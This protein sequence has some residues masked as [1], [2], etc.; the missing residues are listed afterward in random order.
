MGNTIKLNNGVEMPR[1]GYGVYQI[2]PRDTERCVA[3]AIEVGYRHIDTAQCY[4]NEGE[5]G[6]AVRKSGIAREQFFIT[7]KLWGCNGHAD[8]VKSIEESLQ[9]LNLKY[10][11]LLLIH[12][13]SGNYKEIWRAMEDAVAS[14][15]VKSIGVANFLGKTLVDLVEHC[16]IIPAV[17][18]IETHPFRQQIEMQKM[19]ERYGIVL[20]AWSPLAC[21]KNNIF[22]NTILASIADKY[23]KTIAQV[24]L[25]WLYQRGIVIIPKST[26]KERMIENLDIL[27]FSLTEA[28]MIEISKLEIGKSLFNWW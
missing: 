2:P 13:P 18:Q 14:G 8:T 10:I 9:R 26:H 4:Y 6:N 20:E 19:C 24:V 28:D 7:T 27:D 16:R 17:D 15:T 21:G 22:G 11:D 12:E 1:I 3:E 23:N 5:V 25:R